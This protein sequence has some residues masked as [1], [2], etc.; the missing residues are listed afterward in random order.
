MTL[1]FCKGDL[2]RAL[3]QKRAKPEAVE[4]VVMFL[5]H[6]LEIFFLGI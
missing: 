3:K 6:P 2:D 1:I 4:E 5:S